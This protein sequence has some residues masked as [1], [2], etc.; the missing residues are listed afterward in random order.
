VSAGTTS[1]TRLL[2]L[3][4]AVSGLAA[5]RLGRRLGYSV[6]IYDERAGSLA[7]ATS[8]GFA[9]I[10]GAW[11]PITLHGIDLVVTSPGIPE[12]SRP[13]VETLES[14]VTLWSEIEFAWRH[15]EGLPLAAVTGTN[16]KTTVTSLI[17]EM[18][19]ASGVDAR[20][21]G[22]IGTPLAD[23]VGTDLQ[24][25]VVEVSSFQLHYSDR[26]RPDVAVVTNV[27]PDH[28]DWH[29]S[30]DRYLDAKAR[31]VSHQGPT[32][33]LV[34][35]SDDEGARR[36]AE[37]AP[38]RRIGVGSTGVSVDGYGVDRRGDRLVLGGRD[39]R[40]DRLQVSDDAFLVDLA[41]AAAAAEALGADFEAMLGVIEGFKPSA[42]RRTVVGVIDG[43]SFIDDSKATNPH[44]AL[45]AIRS[46][47]SVVL[48]AGG[49]AKGLDVAPLA[50]EPNVR[51]VIAIGESAPVLLSAAGDRGVPAVSMT[52]AVAEACAVAEPGDVVLLAPG[53]A[54]FDMFD[55]YGH[56]GD[57]FAAEV[58]ARG[59]RS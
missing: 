27:A 12:R 56:R 58:A 46:Y 5:A 44:A 38:G 36:V 23:A 6:T 30:F 10:A 16:G 42:H 31:I 32:D 37:R 8:E 19:I 41:L 49:L 54:S 20:P 52:E 1:G 9:T 25:A 4:A 22:N 35:C 17:S 59:E 24:L 53:C 26:F 50:A 33:L 28:L 45:A 34:F 40:I 43:V 11:D 2:V 15:L 21:L 57:V 39:I 47:P 55:S 18:L 51:A 3:G 14:G 13:I 48:I 7:E 29:G